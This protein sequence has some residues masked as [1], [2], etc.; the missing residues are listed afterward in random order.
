MFLYRYVSC[1]QHE[2]YTFMMMNV[3]K[4]TLLLLLIVSVL[5]SSCGVEKGRARFE[6]K[7][8]NI[9][10]AEFYLY[11]EE[12]AFEGVDTIHIV[13]GSFVYERKALEPMLV[14]LLYPNYTQTHVVLEPGKVIKMKGEASKLGVASITGSEENELLTEFRQAH[15]DADRRTTRLAAE[16]FVRSHARTLASVAIFRRYF[17]DRQD[18]QS[19]A[20]L[21]LL[22]VL[23]KAQPKGREVEYI[24]DFFRPIFENS[25]GSYLPDFTVQTI[26]GKKVSLADYH[27]RNLVIAC[28][29]LWQND[30]HGFMRRLGKQLRSAGK[31]W[32]CLVVSMDFNVKA[33]RSHLKRDSLDCDVVCDQLA[34]ETPVV[35]KLGLHY[36]PSCMIVDAQGKIIQRDV[37]DLSEAKIK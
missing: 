23:T 28:V 17:T 15:A 21:R 26:D 4:P 16:E 24:N 37:M 29:G 27:G 20:A 14:T 10:N 9:T 19:E 3:A 11:S 30:S 5:L 18:V 7:I 12:G 6:G 22:D 1:G 31:D 35:R 33:L 34:F 36:V 25:V 32:D 8:A 2:L 13:D